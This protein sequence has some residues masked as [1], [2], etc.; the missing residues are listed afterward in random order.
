MFCVCMLLMCFFVEG[1]V[2]KQKI[3]SEMEVALRYTL[4]PQFNTVFTI[5]NALHCF[6]SSMYVSIYIYIVINLE[7]TRM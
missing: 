6:N 2:L 3:P 7:H 1:G 5:Q 4:L